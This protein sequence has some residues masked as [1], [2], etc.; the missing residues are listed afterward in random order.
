VARASERALEGLQGVFLRAAEKRDSP[1]DITRNSE[2]AESSW[3]RMSRW[4]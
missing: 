1:W 4:V 2:D 3:E